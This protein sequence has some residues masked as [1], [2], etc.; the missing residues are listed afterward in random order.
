[1]ATHS[2]LRMVLGRKQARITVSNLFE[3]YIYGSIILFH[4]PVYE[5]L[6]K[7][8]RTDRL[9]RELQLV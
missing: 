1:V 7:S 3:E 2:V 8:F 9:E 5:G 6:S 4:C